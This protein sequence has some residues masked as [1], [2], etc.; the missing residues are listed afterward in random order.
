MGKDNSNVKPF[1]ST[2]FP[3]GRTCGCPGEKHRPTCDFY[4]EPV[5]IPTFEGFILAA[6]KLSGHNSHIFAIHRMMTNSISSSVKLLDLHCIVGGIVTEF[7][8]EG[9]RYR[10]T[11]EVLDE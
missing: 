1:I 5:Y 6:T 10:N 7:V 9:R 2:K 4:N 3:E 8:A 11:L